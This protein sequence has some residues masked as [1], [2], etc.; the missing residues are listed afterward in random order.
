MKNLK[1]HGIIPPVVTLLDEEERVDE[2]AFREHLNHLIDAG[3][4]GVFAFL[5]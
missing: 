4:H 5:E 1:I 2:K 3:V